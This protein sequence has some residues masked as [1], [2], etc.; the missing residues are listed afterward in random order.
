MKRVLLL[1]TGGTLAMAG[2]RSSGLR[3]T[4]F[5]QTLRKRAPE[6]LGMARVEFELFSNLD[7]AEMQPE[8][9]SRLADGLY[10][11]LPRVDGAVVTHGTDTLPYTAA[12]LSFMLPGLPK[13]VVLTGA[14]RPLGQ[15]RSDARA[16]LVDAMTCALEGPAEVGV[17][18]GSRLFRGN[19]VCKVKVAENDAF[20]SPNHPPLGVL[21]VEAAFERGLRRRARFALQAELEPRVFLLKVFPGLDPEVPLSLLSRIRGLVVEVYGAGTFPSDPS[22]GRSLLPLFRGARRKGVPVVLVSQSQKN[23]LD[24]SLYASGRSALREGALSGGDMTAAAAVV[25]L[26]VGLRRCGS[27]TS[28][29]TFMKRSLAGEKS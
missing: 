21:G 4:D 9:W 12:A 16:N 22:W 2:N 25:K 18:F 7:S 13:P 29:A 15:V 6:I 10:R 8:H 1:H 26:M 5:F 27:L 19:R 24:P 11:R 3:P 20:D 17:C 28:L 23:P 14:Q